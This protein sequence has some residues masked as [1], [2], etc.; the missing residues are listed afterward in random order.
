MAMQTRRHFRFLQTALFAA[1]QAVSAADADDVPWVSRHAVLR[2]QLQ[3]QPAFVVGAL[4]NVGMSSDNNDD[5]E[6]TRQVFAQALADRALA[7]FQGQ[8][9][10][11]FFDPSRVNNASTRKNVMQQ[12]ASTVHETLH[13]TGEMHSTPDGA[14]HARFQQ[15]FDNFVVQGGNIVVHA[16]AVGNVV[17]VNGE[18]VDCR[19][20]LSSWYQQSFP[21]ASPVEDALSVALT[22]LGLQLDFDLISQTQPELALVVSDKFS[23]CLAYQSNVTYWDMDTESGNR[24]WKEDIFYLDA[25]DGDLCAREPLV[26]G[27]FSAFPPE[28]SSSNWLHANPT[29]RR[30]LSNNMTIND[31][32][33]GEDDEEL[34]SPEAQISTYYCVPST[35]DTEM[36][37]K[38]GDCVLASDSPIPIA[39]GNVAIDSA[40][41][42]A[43]A[44]FNYFWFFHGL[45]SLNGQ[46][47]ELISYVLSDEFQ[48]ANGTF[49]R[50]G[51]LVKS[52]RTLLIVLVVAL[53]QPTGMASK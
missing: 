25:F 48:L 7:F 1:T 28:R 18:Y 20:V 45:N 13:W 53:S 8:L 51:I 37:P 17:A 31:D 35:E 24:I 4:G 42:Y 10:D 23:C 41:N 3:G 50:E 40:H 52:L 44:T 21:L 15:Y 5:D 19:H 26:F 6:N 30:S 49:L 33:A 14:S 34:S 32:A 9:D 46:G 38:T 39:T 12:H 43:L 29:L 36:P 16:D 22:S 27:A 47:Y 2:R 11:D